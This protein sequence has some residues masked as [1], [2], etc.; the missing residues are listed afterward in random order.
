MITYKNITRVRR[1]LENILLLVDELEEKGIPKE[2]IIN[3][4]INEPKKSSQEDERI[5][6]N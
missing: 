5:S 4:I 6:K 1:E 3:T 2:V